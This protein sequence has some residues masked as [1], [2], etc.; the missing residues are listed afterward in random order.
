[1]LGDMTAF[2]WVMY[3]GDR[4]AYELAAAA[5]LQGLFSRFPNVKLLLSEQGTVWI[6]YF[7]RKMDHAF[8]MGRKAT[9]GKLEKRPS[10]YFREHVVR[11]AVP[12]GERRP[13]DRVGRRRAARLRLRLPP[14]RR[15]AGPAAY[16][17]S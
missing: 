9:W 12:G 13:G 2:Q 16:R 14:R 8:L 5:M 6:P 15:P 17:V 11:R 1:M 10:E 4:P 3:Y 7:V